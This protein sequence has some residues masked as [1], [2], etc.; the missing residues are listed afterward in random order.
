MLKYLARTFSIAVSVGFAVMAATWPMRA[1]MMDGVMSVARNVLPPNVQTG[2]YQIT[3]QDCFRPLVQMGTGTTP[4]STVTLPPS[5]NVPN[6][7]IIR[8]KNGDVYAGNNT[9]HGMNLSGFPA[10]VTSSIIWPS[11]SL[12]VVATVSGWQTSIPLGLWQLTREV[13]FYVR[14]DGSDTLCDGLTNAASGSASGCAFLTGNKPLTVIGDQVDINTAAGGIAA[15]VYSCSSP[16]CTVTS[17]SQFVSI[18]GGVSFVGGAPYIKGDDCSTAP[19]LRR[20]MPELPSA[21]INICGFEFAG[22]A[23]VSYGIYAGGGTSINLYGPWQCDAMSA[24]AATGFPAGACMQSNS[25][26]KI[27]FNSNFAITGSMGAVFSF[28]NGAYMEVGSGITGTISGSLTW[29][30]GFAYSGIGG[31]SG[32]LGSI[33]FAGAG[34]GTASAGPGCNIARGASLNINASG[35]GYF[36]GTANCS[37]GAG[38]VSDAAGTRASIF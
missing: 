8:L 4:Q 15:V 26:A 18:T 27:Y 1:D 6:G 17:N 3:T 21:P 28:V 38:G 14:T 11:Q 23:N 25:T 29:T 19:V 37:V 24:T 16:P 34:A 30:N 13:D 33:T 7:C 22:G 32:V 12:S 9:G 2:P 36:P 31:G 20:I 35:A 5:T 10:D